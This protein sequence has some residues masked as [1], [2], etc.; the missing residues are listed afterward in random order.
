MFPLN[1]IADGVPGSLAIAARGTRALESS[2]VRQTCGSFTTI[3]NTFQCTDVF[4]RVDLVGQVRA[5]E[6][7]A[8]VSASPKWTGNIVASYLYGDLTASVLARYVGGAKLDNE[9]SDDPL[10]PRYR[11]AAGQLL[12]G[13]V[14]DNRVDP[15]LDF[16]LAASL[17]LEVQDLPQF[18]L[19]GSI[20]N[21]FDKRP[22]FTGGGISGAS[23]QY[24]D[25]LGRS[26][27][28]GVRLRF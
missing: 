5:R 4:T 21:V 23:A 28:V 8:G 27:R 3:D 12:Y 6:F 18:Q 20:A 7:V 10:D 14:D 26:F 1:R 2:G 17:D 9:W 11:N 24:Y 13:S 16:S 22:P 25:T 19:F 15:W